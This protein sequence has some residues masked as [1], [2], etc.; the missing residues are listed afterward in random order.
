MP[1]PHP[2]TAR[3]PASAWAALAWVLALLLAQTLGLVHGVLHGQGR[4]APTAGVHAP[5]GDAPPGWLLGWAADHDEGDATCQQID[6]LGH[7]P[8]LPVLE[9]LPAFAPAVA[10]CATAPALPPVLRVAQPY[11]P[12]APPAA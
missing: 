1:L 9:S 11:Q 2:V 5:R 8:A 3:R 12:R 6:Q 4:L 7:G 10:V